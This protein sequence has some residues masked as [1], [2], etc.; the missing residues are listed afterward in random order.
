MSRFDIRDTAEQAIQKM[1]HHNIQNKSK[2]ESYEDKKRVI[3]PLVGVL[4]FLVVV[5]DAFF[6]FSVMWALFFRTRAIGSNV[7]WR[8]S[9]RMIFVS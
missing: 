8:H 3:S 7:C 9:I 4:A 1:K 5:L 6:A 2:K